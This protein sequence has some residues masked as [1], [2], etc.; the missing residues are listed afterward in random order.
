MV[1]VAA[2]GLL[3]LA[4]TVGSSSDVIGGEYFAQLGLPWI[5]RAADQVA[6]AVVLGLGA[7]PLLALL[8]PIGEH[9]VPDAYAAGAPLG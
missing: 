8:V 3:A 6:G 2:V 5:D 1:V 9:F 4:V 7:V